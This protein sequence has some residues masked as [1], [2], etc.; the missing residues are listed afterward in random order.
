MQALIRKLHLTRLKILDEICI[1]MGGRVAE[2]ITFDDISTGASQDISQATDLA[3]KMTTQWGMSDK[4]GTIN[5]GQK[6]EPIFIGKEIATHKD[7]SEK[8]AEVIDEE[9]KRIITEQYNKAKKILTTNK[10]KLKKLAET[11]FEKETLD[12]EEIYKLIDITHKKTGKEKEKG[13]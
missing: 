11:L 2:E 3:R 9:I 4:L 8:T 13:K 7:Y 1:L 6:D 12:A 5:Y 10:A